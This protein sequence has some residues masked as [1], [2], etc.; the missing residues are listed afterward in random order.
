MGLGPRFRVIQLYFLSALDLAAVLSFHRPAL[1][2]ASIV[3][4]YQCAL[5]VRYVHRPCR[6]WLARGYIDTARL[7]PGPCSTNRAHWRN[8]SRSGNSRHGAHT[9]SCHRAFLDQCVYR[10]IVRRFARRV[11]DSLTDCS[12]RKRR[13]IGGNSE[14]LQS[15]RRNRGADSHWLHRAIDAFFFWSVHCRYGLSASWDRRLYILAGADRTDPR[16]R[17]KRRGSA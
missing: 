17:L 16:S 4:L 15:A 12:T 2:F 13:H 10:R 3:A 14:F 5:A 1:G 8:N 9:Q 7:E 11:V 6:G